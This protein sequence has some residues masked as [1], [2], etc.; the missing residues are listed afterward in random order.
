MKE[1]PIIIAGAGIAGLSAALALGR[2]GRKVLVLEKAPALT[3]IGAGLQLS[4]NA[5]GHLERWGVLARLKGAELAPEA[6]VIRR[7]R[8]ATVLARLPLADAEKRWGA[9][10]LVAHR[11]DLQQ[12]LRAAVAEV[13]AVGW[14][15]MRW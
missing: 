4:P 10:Y 6:V 9:P 2:S 13:R 11:A 15:A 5:S 14:R 8:D 12:A 1:L 7:G 3:E